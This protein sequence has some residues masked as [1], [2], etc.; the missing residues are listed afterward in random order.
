[1]STGANDR[2]FADYERRASIERESVLA[3]IDSSESGEVWFKPCVN[4]C[5]LFLSSKNQLSIITFHRCY[6]NVEWYSTMIVDTCINMSFL[7]ITGI[8]DNGR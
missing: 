6:E 2:G 8:R 7:L 4:S 1:M 3:R 5:F